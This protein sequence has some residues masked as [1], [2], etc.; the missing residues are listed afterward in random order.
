MQSPPPPP[1][2]CTCFRL[3]KLARLVSQRYDRELAQVGININ[4]YSILRR[5]AATPRAV[6]ELARELGMDRTTLSRDLKPLAASGWVETVSGEDARQRLI[7]VTA[8]GKRVVARAQP[9][10]RRAQDAI[11][12][13]IG[14][15]H[16]SALNAQLDGA[17]HSLDTGA[18]A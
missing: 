15:D 6:G 17:T 7:R 14:V 8:S 1:S 11:E 16:I 13:S 2:Q 3:R 4:Q 5:A 18:A 9:I 12:A 10:W